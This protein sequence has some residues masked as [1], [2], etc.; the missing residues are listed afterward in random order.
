MPTVCQ[1]IHPSSLPTRRRYL[2]HLSGRSDPFGLTCCSHPA[3]ASE[4]HPESGL[5]IACS[6]TLRSRSSGATSSSHR[7]STPRR[8]KQDNDSAGGSGGDGEEALTYKPIRGDSVTTALTRA[9]QAAEKEHFSSHDLRRTAATNISAL[10]YPDEMVGRI[11]NH[12][13]RT[14]TARYNRHAHLDE[15]RQA[16]EAWAARLRGFVSD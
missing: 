8:P 9:I 5:L 3:P 2:R 6:P 4:H 7:R 10:G 11:L 16:L 14:V 12:V 13:N 1:S 15:K